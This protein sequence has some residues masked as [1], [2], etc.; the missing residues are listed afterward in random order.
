MKLDDTLSLTHI[1]KQGRDKGWWLYDT[2]RGMNLA[3]RAKSK[4]EA[5]YKA[6]K[7]YQERLLEVESGYKTLKDTVEEFIKEASPS[8]EEW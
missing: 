6:I 5:Y 3:M 7:Y 1:E 4:D 2:T 8:R